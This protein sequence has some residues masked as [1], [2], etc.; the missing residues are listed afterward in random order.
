MVFRQIAAILLLA[1]IPAAG[2]ALWHPR[3]PAWQ[4]DEVTPAADCE[5]LAAAQAGA[6]LVVYPKAAHGFDNPEFAGGKRILGMWLQY[7]R[8]AAEGSM[9]ALRDFL[10]KR[11]AR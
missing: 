6:T 4:S 9:A 8:A 2:T 1:V 11:L 5:R 7:D 3:R 10:G